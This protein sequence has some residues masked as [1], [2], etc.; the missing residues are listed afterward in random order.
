MGLRMMESR[1][2]SVRGSQHAILTDV[3]VRCRRNFTFRASLQPKE[4]DTGYI[5]DIAAHPSLPQLVTSRKYFLP[6]SD[7]V[8]S[9]I[10]P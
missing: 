1:A 8:A 4:S 7:D 10:L 5:T 9:R 2:Y 3:G 6:F